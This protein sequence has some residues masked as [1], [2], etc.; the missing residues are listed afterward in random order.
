LPP[1]VDRI[2]LKTVHI[3]KCPVVVPLSTLTDDAAQRWGIDVQQGER[4]RQ[5]LLAEPALAGK[6]AKVHQRERFDST[7]DPDLALYSGGFF[8]SDDRRRMDEIIGSDPASLA[9]FPLVFDDPRLPEMLFR[10]RARNWPE[11]L[12]AEELL[13]WQEYRVS[14]LLDS[15]G[16]ASIT[17]D[18]Y[19]AKL[20]SLETDSQ[21]SPEKRALIGQ[22]LAWAEHIAPDKSL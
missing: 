22:L 19:L 15:D 7:G 1:G 9:G 12:S 18:E 10:Y 8:S 3:N 4:H 21:L 16:G 5:R 17:L 14:R 2:P 20:D 11:L 6:I 13:R